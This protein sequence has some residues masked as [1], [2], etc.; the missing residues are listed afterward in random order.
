MI[1]NELWVHLVLSWICSSTHSSQVSTYLMISYA[2]GLDSSPLLSHTIFPYSYALRAHYVC[3]ATL[4]VTFT[5]Y[6]LLMTQHIAKRFEY[7]SILYRGFGFWHSTKT[8][9]AKGSFII[10]F[11]SKIGRLIINT[12]TVFDFV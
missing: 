5:L 10:Y 8:V 7:H 12:I 6:I 9:N 1:R 11:S 3:N 4:Q 2:G